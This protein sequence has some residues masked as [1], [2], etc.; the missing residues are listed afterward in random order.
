MDNYERLLNAISKSSGLE[1]D[2][3]EKR[4][5]AKQEKISCLIIKD[6]ADQNVASE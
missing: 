2:E 6:G 5:N 1:K 4:V 3:I